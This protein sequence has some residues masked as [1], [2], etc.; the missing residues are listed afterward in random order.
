MDGR[1]FRLAC[2][3][4]NGCAPYT[5]CV[6]S[7]GGRLGLKEST[8]SSVNKDPHAP[9]TVCHPTHTHVVYQS[10]HT[11]SGIAATHV[12]HPTCACALGPSRAPSAIFARTLS[13]LSLASPS[14]FRPPSP[15]R[16]YTPCRSPASRAVSNAAAPLVAY[17]ARRCA[18]TG[19]RPAL[20]RP[21][22]HLQPRDA[23]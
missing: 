22:S 9:R 11:T 13:R 16:V 3:F 21:H 15:P 8:N 23:P 10:T 12:Y 19:T 5:L 14:P 20:G 2:E 1:Q 4:G 17:P 7:G 6:G 18:C